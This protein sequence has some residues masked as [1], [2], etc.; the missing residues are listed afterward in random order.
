MELLVEN[1]VVYSGAAILCLVVVLLYLRRQRRNSK[2]VEE[3]IKL[4][5]LEGV[6]EP[7]S[8]HPVVDPN[9]CIGTGACITACPEKDILGI[10]NGKATTRGAHERL[11]E[12][13]FHG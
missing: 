5:K 6:F 9:K 4:A 11:P 2:K 10:V 3:K 8:L 7:V 12:E 1:I 13:A